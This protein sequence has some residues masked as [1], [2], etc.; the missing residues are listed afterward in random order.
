MSDS[1][2]I[3]KIQ[4]FQNELLVYDVSNQNVDLSTVRYKVYKDLNE[5]SDISKNSLS[6]ACESEYVTYEVDSYDVLS[7]GDNVNF[8]SHSFNVLEGSYEICDG[9]LLNRYKLR[10]RNGLRQKRDFNNKII[11]SSLGG[12]SLY[13]F[14]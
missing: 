10:S 11:G 9:I 4:E 5:F 7:I 12:E 2:L 8:M 13:K 3:S 6:D 1:I 14:I